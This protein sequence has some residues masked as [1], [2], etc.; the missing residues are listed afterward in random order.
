MWHEEISDS[1]NQT[2]S[3]FD[4][5]PLATGSKDSSE[6]LGNPHVSQPVNDGSCLSTT[7]HFQKTDN[8]SGLNGERLALLPKKEQNVV[9]GNAGNVIKNWSLDG[10]YDGE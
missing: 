10:S 3:C 5:N 1:L 4:P 2:L 8:A 6:I 9:K 7:T